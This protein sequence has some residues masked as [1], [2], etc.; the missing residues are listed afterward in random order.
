[1]RKG[2]VLAVTVLAFTLVAS[3]G[4]KAKKQ[5]VTLFLDTE[6]AGTQLRAGDYQVAIENGTAIFFRSGKEVAKTAVRGEDAGQK[7]E[8]NSMVYGEDGKSLREIR[9]GG[10]KTKLVIEGG[11]LGARTN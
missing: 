7:Y 5:A 9:L 10:S 3:A 4:P 1:M 2:F 11:A 8:T 6:I